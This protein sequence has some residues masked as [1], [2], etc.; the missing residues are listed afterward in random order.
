MAAIKHMSL[1]KDIIFLQRID[2]VKM[3]CLYSAAGALVFPSL[4]EG[5][6]MPVVEAMACGCPVIASD[7]PTT[8]E[9]GGKSVS[10][11]NPLDIESITAAMRVFQED[12]HKRLQARQSGFNT[13]RDYS[14]ESVMRKLVDAY[15]SVKIR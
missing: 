3:P 15:N 10:L 2:E 6:G 13:A 7:I 4:Y 5:G 12:T 11:F 1:E 14:P 9:F 8:R